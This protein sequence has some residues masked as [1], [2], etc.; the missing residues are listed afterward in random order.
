VHRN[1]SEVGPTF[2]E[3]LGERGKTHG[4][5]LENARVAQSTKELWR[6]EKGWK[7]LNAGQREALEMIAHK[8]ARVLCGDPCCVDHWRDIG[9]YVE[10]VVRELNDGDEP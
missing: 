6:N 9:G 8:I 3:L 7:K 2:D 4:D 5:W 10:L 1:L